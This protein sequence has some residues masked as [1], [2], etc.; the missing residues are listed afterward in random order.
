MAGSATQRRASSRIS[1]STGLPTTTKSNSNSPRGP[2]YD[3]QRAPRQSPPTRKQDNNSVAPP[4]LFYDDEV[5]KMHRDLELKREQQLLEARTRA[6]TRKLRNERVGTKGL[7]LRAVILYTIASWLLVCPNQSNLSK[8]DPDKHAVCVAYDQAWTVAQQAKFHL[9]PYTDVAWQQAQPYLNNVQTRAEPVVKHVRPHYNKAFNIANHVYEQRQQ[10]HDKHVQPVVD[11]VLVWFDKLQKPIVDVVER[12]YRQSLAPSVEWYTREY[13]E[14]YNKHAR[15]PVKQAQHA[16]QYHSRQAYDTMSPVWT[17]GVPF[18]D[19]HMRHTVIPTTQ[20]TYSTV[21]HGY[22][23]QIHP[24]L[25]IATKHCLRFYKS[26]IVPTLERFWS[27]FIAPQLDKI[28][29]KVYEYKA[30]K[31]RQQSVHVVDQVEQ[32]VLAQSEARDIEDFVA[33]LRQLSDHD[34][35]S[36]D[37]AASVT[38]T[39]TVSSTSTEPSLSAAERK[40][41]NANKRASL[42]RLQ[43]SYEKELIKLGQTQHDL[44]LTRLIELRQSAT[45]DVP[46]RFNTLLNSLDQE[47]DKMIVRLDKYFE[48]AQLETSH[49]P[50]QRV[51]ESEFLGNKAVTKVKQMANN[52]VEEVATYRQRLDN[53]EHKAVER[54]SEA[55]DVLLAKAQEELGYGWTWLDDVSHKDWQ[56]Y[57][58]L[59]KAVKNW[60]TNYQG[61]RTGDID[62]ATLSQFQVTKLLDQVDTR[63]NEVV[64]DFVTIMDKRLKLGQSQLQGEWTGVANEA[65]KAYEAAGEKFAQAASA[66]KDAKSVIIGDGSTVETRQDLSGSASSIAGAAS[67]AIGSV[68]NDVRTV[69][70]TMAGHASQSVLSAIGIEPSPTD[71]RQSAGSVAR[72]AAAA[73]RS[74]SSAAA[75]ALSRGVGGSETRPTDVGQSATSLVKVASKS[76]VQGYS[77]VVEKMGSGQPMASQASAAVKQARDQ[78]VQVAGEASQAAIRAVGQEPSPTNVGQSVTS[79]G[80]LVSKVVT[81]QARN[82]AQQVGRASDNVVSAAS[83]VSASASSV[84]EVVR[85][86]VTQVASSGSSVL[87]D[88]TRTTAEGVQESASSVAKQVKSVINDKIPHVE[89]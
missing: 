50:E 7:L 36:I 59:N 21:H 4:I 37:G 3:D 76:V 35:V 52:V 31:T 78:V 14:W 22:V 48:R 40:N 82:V 63:A 41:L 47:S 84:G 38:T 55:L 68:I 58:G 81:E 66:V 24:R 33:E 69:V 60:K 77:S 2:A 8:D 13:N 71:F 56:R 61:L 1:S 86:Q 72:S 65:A 25:K 39:S 46:K 64:E 74:A 26:N 12:Q 85:S 30:K 54:A 5:S 32:Q 23:N 53:S 19:R 73:A 27:L 17:Q 75:A 20:K 87:H 79:V 57:H 11:Q 16:V 34:V 80:N 49:T 42:E 67:S 45:Q 70:P 43:T 29:E 15:E 9:K 28:R 62:D 18:L 89:L 10:L 51:Q 44:L 6:A 83:A 88:A